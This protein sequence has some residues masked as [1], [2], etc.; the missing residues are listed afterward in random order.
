M[1]A[2]DGEIRV[3]NMLLQDEPHV[4]MFDMVVDV[5]EAMNKD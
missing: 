3:R 2:A 1:V 4:T 5:I